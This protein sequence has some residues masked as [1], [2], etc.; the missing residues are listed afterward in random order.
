MCKI[1]LV[2]KLKSRST[3]SKIYKELRS[4]ENKPLRTQKTQES[5]TESQKKQ[6]EENCS[7]KTQLLNKTLIKLDSDVHQQDQNVAAIIENIN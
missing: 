7:G 6:L 4:T 2:E 3:G 1:D 5:F